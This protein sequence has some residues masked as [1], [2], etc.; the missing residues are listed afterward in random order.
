MPFKLYILKGKYSG[1]ALWP[2]MLLKKDASDIVI[3][4]E[5]IHIQQ[6]KELMIIPFYI[7]Y[8]F[9]YLFNLMIYYNHN[10]AYKNIIFEREAYANAYDKGYLKTRTYMAFLNYL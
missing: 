6:Q 8:V 3:N 9:N 4:H 10:K 2:F 1:M 7:L 5:L